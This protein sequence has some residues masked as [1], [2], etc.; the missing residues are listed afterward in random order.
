MNRQVYETMAGP[1]EFFG[2]GTLK[3][4][5]VT[6]RLEELE[7]PVLITS[8]A[9]D[10]V[11]PRQCRLLQ[12]GIAGSRWEVFDHSAH[13]AVIEEPD[14]YRAVHEAFLASADPRESL[15]RDAAERRPSTTWHE[16]AVRTR[17][18]DASRPRLAPRARGHAQS[19]PQGR[20]VTVA[21]RA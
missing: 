4:W 12:A 9:Y 3:D 18:P 8:G 11:T 21:V 6:D 13:C 20:I 17:R 19:A 1:S 14:R 2:T 10:E 5:D 15:R 7:L 16:P